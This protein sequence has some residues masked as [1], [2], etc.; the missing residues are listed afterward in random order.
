MLPIILKNMP[1][2]SFSLFLLVCSICLL[3]S[4]EN[5]LWQAPISSRPVPLQ[6]FGMHIH[7]AAERTPW[8][9]TS[10]GTWRL[11]DTNTSWADLEPARD[12]W[13]FERLDRLVAIAAEHRTEIVLP[14]AYTPPWISMRPNE[15]SASGRLGVAAP[16]KDLGAWRN[17]V[18]TIATRYRGKIQYYE[19][20]N[21]PNDPGFYSGGLDLLVE[22][23]KDA[24]Y[25][26]KAA[27]P[28]AQVLSPAMMGSG[29]GVRML[30]A[31][32]QKGGAAS[33]DILS[34]H[35]YVTPRPPESMVRDVAE[36]RSVMKD[37]GL[38]ERPLWMTEVGWA[39][40]YRYDP[41]SSPA[42]VVRTYLLGWALGVD[43]VF[44]Y[45]W[46]NQHWSTIQMIMP[47]G[48]IENGS[49]VAF[50]NIE[51][52]MIGRQLKGCGRTGANWE[53]QFLDPSTGKKT[54]V[55]WNQDERVAVSKIRAA[56]VTKMIALTPTALRGNIEGKIAF[57]GNPIAVNAK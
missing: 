53:C 20:W 32:L 36:V 35:F 15:K 12:E 18:R 23:G 31:Y 44:W 8:P 4:S 19:L 7:Y 37:Y 25:I 29:S 34:Y 47:N 14:L 26:I 33:F 9:T 27:D 40:P 41:S 50:S 46:D 28:D 1:L 21:E 3:I 13:H 17:Y 57:D 55:L 38:L 56:D 2:K 5:Q 24:Y 16:P 51:T 42:Y 52:L 49:A 30:K 54:T 22:M 48:K 43:R 45:A 11:W 10:I 39:A 6:Y